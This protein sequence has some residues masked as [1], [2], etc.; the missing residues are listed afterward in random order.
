MKTIF[1]VSFWGNPGSCSQ[2]F[3]KLELDLPFAPMPGVAFQNL[4]W[5]G[6]RMPTSIVF[7]TTEG[8]FS[9]LFGLDQICDPLHVEKIAKRRRARFVGQMSDYP[10]NSNTSYAIR[11][12]PAL[13][14]QSQFPLMPP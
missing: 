12:S 3:A 11:K 5:K 4:A 8:E 13:Q 6:E 10:H 14:N 1:L 9:V 7:D 2:G